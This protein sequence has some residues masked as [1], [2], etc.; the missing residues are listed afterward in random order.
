M[1]DDL[2]VYTG[3]LEELVGFQRDY[4]ESLHWRTGEGF[5]LAN[6]D[7]EKELT[8][9]RQIDDLRNSAKR[10]TIPPVSE[11]TPQFL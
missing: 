7:V 11:R 8:I 1:F 2:D 3:Y 9:L 6:A 10:D 5:S 4:R